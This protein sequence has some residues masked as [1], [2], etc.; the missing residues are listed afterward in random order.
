MSRRFVANFLLTT[1]VVGEPAAVAQERR[2]R[3]GLQAV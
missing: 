3:L 1:P 2:M